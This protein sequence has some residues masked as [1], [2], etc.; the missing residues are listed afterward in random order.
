M[1]QTRRMT[2]AAWHQQAEL[3]HGQDRIKWRFKCPSCGHAAAVEDWKVAG[4]PEG[5]VAFSCVG[6]YLVEPSK[7][8]EAAFRNQGQRAVHLHEWRSVR[9][10]HLDG[11]AGR[12]DRVTGVRGG[13]GR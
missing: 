4:A 13:S 5:A 9:C 7:A 2:L 12:R 10:Q 6:R 8:A 3:A 1:R 11:E